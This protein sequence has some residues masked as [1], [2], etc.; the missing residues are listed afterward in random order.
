MKKL[1]L[2]CIFVLLLTNAYS[3]NEKYLNVII[4]IN[5]EIVVGN[6]MHMQIAP[7]VGVQLKNNIDVKYYPGKLILPTIEYQSIPDSGKVLLMFDYYQNS[8]Y[9]KDVINYKI[10]LQKSWL[11][12]TYLIIKVFDLSSGKYKGIFDPISKD[13]NYTFA[14][15]SPSYHFELIARRKLKR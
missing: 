12:S 9:N 3:Q 1:L 14:I 6:I 15:V 8:M 11:A 5:D 4:T 10:D 7:L 13:Q 2:S